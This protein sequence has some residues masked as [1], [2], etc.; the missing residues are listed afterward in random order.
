MNP[1]YLIKITNLTILFFCLIIIQIGLVSQITGQTKSDADTQLAQKTA[2]QFVKRMQ[3]T[4]DVTPLIKE[5]FHPKII[6]RFVSTDGTMLPIFL[7]QLDESQKLK[8]LKFL[9]N[10][11]YLS[12]T[13]IYLSEERRSAFSPKFAEKLEKMTNPDVVKFTTYEDFKLRL[14]ET[15]KNILEV[16]EYLIKNKVEQSL[17]FQNKLEIET[18]DSNFDYKVKIYNIRDL[19]TEY[20]EFN[21]FDKKKKVFSVTTPLYFSLML[22]KEGKKMKIVA[23]S[24]VPD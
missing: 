21:K 20:K 8:F 13:I 5:M 3:E 4:R 10:Q 19:A 17:E 6:K 2:K 9:I 14:P 15:E 24:N 22:V 23:I 7:N 1:R 11:F 16:R 12:S 18:K